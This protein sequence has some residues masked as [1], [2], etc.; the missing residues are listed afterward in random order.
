VPDDPASKTEGFFPTDTCISSSQLSRPIWT[1][2]AYIHL[3]NPK[4]HKV[5]LQKLTQFSQ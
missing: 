1:K 3:E 2:R 5:F 4:L